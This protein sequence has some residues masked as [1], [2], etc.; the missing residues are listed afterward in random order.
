MGGHKA[1]EVA[2]MTASQILQTAFAQFHDELLAD[3]DLD[4]GQSLPRSGELLA[5]SIRLANAAI[6]SK[7]ESDPGLAGMGTTVVAIALEDD[8]ASIAHVGDSRA[9]LMAEKKLI[10]LTA[11]HSFVAELARRENVSEKEAAGMYG[12]NVITRA[13]GVR[14]TVE[15][16]LRLIKVR[17]GDTFILCSDGLCGFADDED[18][19]RAA[20]PV[21]EFLGKLVSELVQLANDRGGADNVTVIA[22]RVEEVG[23]SSYSDLEVQTLPAE[24]QELLTVEDG[25]VERMLQSQVKMN[26]PPLSQ[27]SPSGANRTLMWVIFLIF[28]VVAVVMIYISSTD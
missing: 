25:W 20:N 22:L 9:Y 26:E 13:L 7:A 3:P 5:K 4:L 24:S 14:S 23:E 19:F 15:V 8:I 16:D 2:S 1:G 18:I 27:E 6:Q 11:D 12:K 10:Q 21:R 17:P 28:A